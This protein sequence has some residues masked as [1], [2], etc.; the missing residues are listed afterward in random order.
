M[1]HLLCIL[2]AVCA[3]AMPDT[4]W[5]DMLDVLAAGLTLA[6]C[7]TL[8]IFNEAVEQAIQQQITP[9]APRVHFGSWAIILVAAS[10]VHWFPL[11]CFVF[12]FIVESAFYSKVR[13]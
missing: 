9:P 7:L 1:F 13:S 4:A 6:A 3:A 5:P 11:A 12:V 10:M 8:F 2:A